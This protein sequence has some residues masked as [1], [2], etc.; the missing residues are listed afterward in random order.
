M[1]ITTISKLERKTS[2]EIP[3]VESK[4]KAGFPSPAE[5]YLDKKIDLNKELIQHPAAT[6]F[7]RV[8][9]DSMRDAG[10]HS[11][12]MLIVDRAIK[13]GNK[14]VVVA[15]LNGEFTV[16][17]LLKKGNKIELVAENP[18]YETITVTEDSDFEIWGVVTNVIHPV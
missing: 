10:I 2:L 5:D 18:E 3:L 17:R 6:F 8:S 15:L 16:K 12:D 13:P 11:G 1:K 7:V 4:V 14:K 9:G